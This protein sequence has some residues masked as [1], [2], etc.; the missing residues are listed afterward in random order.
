MAFTIFGGTLPGM[1][2]LF[3]WLFAFGLVGFALGVILFRNPVTSAICLVA[4]FLFLAALFVTLEAFFV[5]MVQ[6]IVYAGAVMVL[7]LF[8]IMLL[9]IREEARR[10]IP[11]V[12]LGLVGLLV[13]G[14]GGLFSAV[15]SAQPQG[16]R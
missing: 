7:F 8:I 6:I 4:T 5:A 1:E 11:W 2:A 9:D 16:Q 12:R 13:A 10:P 15:L 3:F 14:F